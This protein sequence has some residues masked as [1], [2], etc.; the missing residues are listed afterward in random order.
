MNWSVEKQLAARFCLVLLVLAGG[1]LVVRHNLARREL[2]DS[3]VQRRMRALERLGEL[4]RMSAAMEASV[5]GYALT[6]RE[7]YLKP[8]REAQ[9]GL[10]GAVGG[11]ADLA[12]GDASLKGRLAEVERA[13]AIRMKHQEAVIRAVRQQGL[14]GGRRAVAGAQTV[15][16]TERIHRMVDELRKEEMGLLAAHVKQSRWADQREFW[17][18]SAFGGAT[19]T[20]LLGGFF[21]L[22]RHLR[23]QLRAARLSRSSEEQLR[24]ILQSIGDGVLAT[25]AEGRVT[26]MNREAERLT[27]WSEGEALGRPVNDVLRL[28]SEEPGGK[29]E[30]VAEEAPRAQAGFGQAEAAVLVSRTGGEVFVAQSAER[31]A[32]PDGAPAGAVQTFREVTAEREAAKALQAS[33]E[34]YRQITEEA[35]YAILIQCQGRFAYVNRA[36]LRMFRAKGA[37][38][39]VGKPLLDFVHPVDRE[40]VAGRLQ[41]LN[42]S[43]VPMQPADQRWLRADGSEFWAQA[44]GNPIN[45]EGRIAAVVLLRDVS[46]PKAA[47]LA[48]A[49]HE[50]QIR[51]ISA[52]IPGGAVYRA[53]QEGEDYR[54]TYIGPGIEA[55][56]GWPAEEILG[57]QNALRALCAEDEMKGMCAAAERAMQQ[58]TTLDHELRIWSAVGKAKWLHFRAMPQPLASGGVQWDGVVVDETA[59]KEA[60]EE[61]QVLNAQ[62]E[63]RVAERTTEALEAQQRWRTVFE[64][65]PAGVLILDPETTLPIE[66][67]DTACRQLGYAPEEFQ[68]LRVQ[69]YEAA[70]ETG[71]GPGWVARALRDG[72][73]E[74]EAK[75]RTKT[76]TLRRVQ[77][78]AKAM[79]LG[80][81]QVVACI[82]SDITSLRIMEATLRESEG[83]LRTL[84]EAIRD[85]AIIGLDPEGRVTTWNQGAEHV[86]GWGWAEVIGRS[87]QMLHPEEEEAAACERLL[88]QARESGGARSERWC[89]RRDGSLF[90]G[91][92]VLAPQLDENGKVL[93][94]SKVTCDRTQRM[95][96]EIEIREQQARL[97]LAQEIGQ[98]G[99]WELNL[100]TGEMRWSQQVHRIFGLDRKTHRPSQEDFLSRVHPEDRGR[101][102]EAG[103]RMSQ[104]EEPA[105]ADY[106]VVD[107]RGQVRWLHSRAFVR[108]DERGQAVGSYGTV[109]DVTER[110]LVQDRLAVSEQRYRGIV[111]TATEGICILDREQRITFVNRRTGEMLGYASG[112]MIGR[113]LQDFLDEEGR[114]EMGRDLK[115]VLEGHAGKYNFRFLTKDGRDCWTIASTAPMR[116]DVGNPVGVLCMI[117]DVTERRRLEEMYQQSQKMEAVGRLAGGIAHDFNN[118]LTVIN[119]YADLLLRSL[120][121]LDPMHEQVRAILDAGQTAA[122]LTQQLLTFS[123]KQVVEPRVSNLNEIVEDARKVF[124]RVLGEDIEL[125]FKLQREPG[126]VRIDRT[127]F[128]QVLM[129]MVVNARDAMPGG[130]RLV[131]ETANVEMES[132]SV[133]GGTEFGP[134]SYVQLIVSDSGMGMDEATRRRVFEPFFTTKELGKGTGLGLATVYGIVR[135]AGGWIWVYCEPG[136]GTTFKIYL[137]RVE[138]EGEA[139]RELEMEDATEDGGSETIL[140]VEDQRVLLRLAETVLRDCGYNVLSAANAGEALLRAGQYEGPIHLLLTDI[141][142]PGVTGREL[143]ERLRPARPEMQVL[144]MSGYAENVIAERGILSAGISFIA[145][146]FSPQSLAKKVRGVLRRKPAPATVL[147]V[148]D[149]AGVREL[150]RHLL[151]PAGYEVLQASHGGM[152]LEVLSGRQ[153]DL[154][155]TDLVMPE[156][157]GLETIQAVRKQY[158]ATK[159]V[160]ISG[161]FGGDFLHAAKKLGANAAL[162]KPIRPDELLETV[163]RLMTR[164]ST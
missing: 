89:V 136:E 83:R 50:P 126:W 28:K 79:E 45:H 15:G 122:E 137:P 129:N 87:Y 58:G 66:F 148:D 72:R 84:L 132:G 145:K 95:R 138:G 32:G 29:V 120:D 25:D 108:R 127:Q 139:E 142:M 19:V 131:I 106:R 117:D 77:V 78:T 100:A 22:R 30:I 44:T 53:V 11:M 75:H 26:R 57:R 13:L 20:V 163:E 103:R 24:V 164:A 88:G 162:N 6:G 34:R 155:I 55:L 98:L 99:D 94:F 3:D 91:E 141:V 92:V 65:A 102:H 156:Q 119:G 110:V 38:E 96:A 59:R 71:E 37:E 9:A 48:V 69:D 85:Y 105:V 116:D 21:R 68:Q 10:S 133:D 74:F 43:G 61:L 152:A 80:S 1:A 101:F 82:F 121:R 157:E 60:E 8:Y 12:G 125:Q 16:E 31:L 56:T 67:N 158:P 14:E 62:L 124:G 97:E 130:G 64:E 135:Q 7:E 42:G 154:M 143:A 73:A 49:E 33:E 46:R 93:G 160:A 23:E 35:P 147:V 115:K 36:A 113:P 149:E 17:A 150:I 161:A 153:V 76:G 111:E 40:L 90:W 109:Q 159:I 146:P 2:A 18:F 114:V 140:V 4:A 112:E 134:G 27:G 70:A 54:F 107:A 123:R 5:N 39:L 52:N 86:F 144:Y 104:A 118:L 151:E 41:L 81:K 47:E 63:R 51:T 128:L